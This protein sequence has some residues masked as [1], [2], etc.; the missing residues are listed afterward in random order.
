LLDGRAYEVRRNL[1]A[2]VWGRE[3]HLVVD[4]AGRTVKYVRGPA[5]DNAPLSMWSNRWSTMP[6]HSL[7]D[8]RLPRPDH[9]AV[10]DR[11]PGS[12]VPVI[13][14]PFAAGDPLPFWAYGARQG[15]LLFELD[16]D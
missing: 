7:P 8:L 9:R 2:G 12:D 6:V 5:G 10:L 11:V 13:R 14:Q 1:L 3:V 16:D 15:S 4:D